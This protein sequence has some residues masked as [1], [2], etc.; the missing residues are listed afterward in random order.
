MLQFLT[1]EIMWMGKSGM[2]LLRE[3][4]YYILQVGKRTKFTIEAIIS[5]VYAVIVL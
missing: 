1:I 2:S 3:G 4:T 5:D